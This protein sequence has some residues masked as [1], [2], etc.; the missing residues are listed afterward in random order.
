MPCM[1]MRGLCCAVDARRAH[2]SAR[3]AGACEVHGLPAA[4]ADP[5]RI[6]RTST[7][8]PRPVQR[9]IGSHAALSLLAHD[10]C[11]IHDPCTCK[12]CLGPMPHQAETVPEVDRACRVSDDKDKRL[13][14]GLCARCKHQEGCS[15]TGGQK[16]F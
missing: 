15:N 9:G 12:F 16:A 1:P 6:H 10:T 3:T 8:R 5:A 2:Q 14:S 7:A 13:E 11:A 4:V